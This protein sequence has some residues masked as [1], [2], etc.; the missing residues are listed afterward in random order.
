MHICEKLIT[1]SKLYLTS[2]M[3]LLESDDPAHMDGGI[4]ED[5]RRKEKH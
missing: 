3:K 5:R 4:L 1:R 2:E